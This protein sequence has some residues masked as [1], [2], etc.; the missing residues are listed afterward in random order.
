MRNKSS[1]SYS[2]SSS[3]YKSTNESDTT[4]IPVSVQAVTSSFPF[5]QGASGNKFIKVL[6]L[7]K[8]KIGIKR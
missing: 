2:S 4:L 6:F 8:K 1:V 7:K 5:S 3:R